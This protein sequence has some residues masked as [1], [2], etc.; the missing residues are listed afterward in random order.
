VAD[1]PSAAPIVKTEDHAA[2]EIVDRL[3]RDNPRLHYVSDEAARLFREIRL[4]PGPISLAVPPAVIRFLADHVAP[5]HLTLET[6]AGQSTVA[7]A[8]LARHHVCIAPDNDEFERIR[9]YMATIGLPATRVTFISERSDV[10]LP[11]LELGEPIDFALIDGCHGYPIPALDWH[12]VDLHLRIGGI[13]GFD[14]AELA[15]VEN[16]CEFLERNGSYQLI[17]RI[18]ERTITKFYSKLRDEHREWAFQSYNR[19]S[20]WSWRRWLARRR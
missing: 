10:A 4:K 12:F 20:P 7:F 6:G 3:L 16:H 8:A 5:T 13:I 15:S 14:N 9:D 1:A 18:G 11:R 2:R 17:A 19:R